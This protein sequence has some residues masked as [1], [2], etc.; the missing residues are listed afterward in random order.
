[1]ASKELSKIIQEK[2]IMNSSRVQKNH[3]TTSRTLNLSQ[4]Y[5]YHVP[6]N[7][8]D[9]VSVVNHNN[10][11]FTPTEKRFVDF[12]DKHDSKV[13]YLKGKDA[14]DFKDGHAKVYYRGAS[15]GVGDRSDFTKRQRSN[16]GV[17]VYNLPSIWDRY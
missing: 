10:K 14:F 15:I 4:Q 3:L 17:G 1:M 8:K 9:R 12:S 7:K 13:S 5:G 6:T 11:I 2:S 16:R